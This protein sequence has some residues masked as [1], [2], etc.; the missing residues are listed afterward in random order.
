LERSA[1]YRERV[2][3]LVKQL[4][5]FLFVSFAWIF[6]RADSLD[7]ACL[8]VRRIFGS[9]WHDPQIPL[10]MLV[11]I[12]VVWL[13]QFLYETKFRELLATSVVR[14]GLVVAMLI[15]LCV[16]SSGGGAFIYFQF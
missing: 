16:C 6:F 10:L 7:D 11:L 1:A 12:G 13:Y 15:Y 4:G 2:P 14:V 5:V 8:I 9:V 3:K